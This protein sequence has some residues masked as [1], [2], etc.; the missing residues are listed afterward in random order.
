M[1]DFSE[2]I[3][4]PRN[5]SRV[6]PF[7][8][9]QAEADHGDKRIRKVFSRWLP[10]DQSAVVQSFGERML[11]RLRDGKRAISFQLDAKDGD[12]WVGDP[13]RLTTDHLV[14][15]AVNPVTTVAQII[16]AAEVV[17]G[18]TYAYTAEDLRLTA[19]NALYTNDQMPPYDLRPGNRRRQSDLRILRR[20]Q[21]PGWRYRSGLRV[22][23]R[24]CPYAM[25]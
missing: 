17:A 6:V 18:T 20:R 25:E 14:D 21:R 7:I 10:S 13:I 4:D 8:D 3:D 1:K 12:I 9:R 23:V 11:L 22:L 2:K 5:F 16:E 19:R 15:G 24:R